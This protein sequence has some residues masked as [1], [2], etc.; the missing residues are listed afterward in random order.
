MSQEELDT[1][2]SLY[3]HDKGGNASFTATA[4]NTYE[5]SIPMSKLCGLFEQQ[6]MIPNWLSSGMRIELRLEETDSTFLVNDTS[7][8]RITDYTIVDPQIHAETFHLMDS[9]QNKLNQISAK[10]SLEIVFTDVHNIS[11]SFSEQTR[12]SNVN[13]AVSRAMGYIA[14]PRTQSDILNAQADSLKPQ[15]WD[16]A[17][18]QARLGSQYYPHQPIQTDVQAYMNV[19]YTQNKLT[20]PGRPTS[21]TFDDFKSTF[22]VLSS[23]LERSNTLKYQG[24]PINNSTTLSLT[25]RW[26]SAVARSLDVFLQYTKVVRVFINQVTVME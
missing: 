16:I 13:K 18:S 23:T 10:N 24:V 1:I 8:A 17:T 15:T 3:G 19:L 26:N 7:P 25:N 6:Q 5:V 9:V 11:D 12:T 2:G 21:V 14:V 4:G 20:H 22:G